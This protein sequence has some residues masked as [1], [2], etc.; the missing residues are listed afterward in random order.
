MATRAKLIE[1]L[2]LTD[3][4]FWPRIPSGLVASESSHSNRREYWRLFALAVGER[5]RAANGH[6]TTF[7][8]VSTMVAGPTAASSDPE[9]ESLAA[10]DGF[11]RR[12]EGSRSRRR[13]RGSSGNGGADQ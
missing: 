3:C 11:F 6:H 8:T 9:L 2:G 13:R 7:V 10:I 1:R 5:P 4:D 12:M